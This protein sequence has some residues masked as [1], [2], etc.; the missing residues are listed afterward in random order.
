MKE[1]LSRISSKGDPQTL[2]LYA[3][4]DRGS[5]ERVQ[6]VGSAEHEPGAVL[7]Q[8]TAED[9]ANLEERIKVLEDKK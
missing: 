6:F 7:Y 1:A 8:G 5:S 2:P 4:T 9:I 3:D